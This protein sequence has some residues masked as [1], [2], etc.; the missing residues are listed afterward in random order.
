[1][2]D[3]DDAKTAEKT[4]TRAEVRAMIAAEM[5]KVQDKYADYDELKKQAEAGDKS[6]SQLD[7][8][9]E[10]LTAMQS[11][12][13]KA[14]AATLRRDVADELG[15]TPK[16]AQRLR[17]STREEL[18]ADGREYM[19]DNGIKPKGERDTTPAGD[20]AAEDGKQGGTETAG[21]DADPPRRGSG[22]PREALRSGAP[23]SQ[24]AP[25][26]TD[27]M[28]LAAMVPRR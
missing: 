4:F 22:R 7:K 16:Q 21:D 26:E 1:M 11:R 10:Q 28:K 18:L 27:P 25:E 3:D 20:A 23:M 12:A 8:I 13:E 5:R 19:E 6:K 2:P 17:G 14:E 15:L 24:G 9:Q